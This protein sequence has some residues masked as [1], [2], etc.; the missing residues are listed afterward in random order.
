MVSSGP[1]S[2]VPPEEGEPIT[3]RNSENLGREVDNIA[4][5]GNVTNIENNVSRANINIT[6]SVHGDE[7]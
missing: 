7:M 5:A 4:L 3:N 6:P 2:V 1:P